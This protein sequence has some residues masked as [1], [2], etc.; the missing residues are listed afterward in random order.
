MS[1]TGDM[2]TDTNQPPLI[3]AII[4][5]LGGVLLRRKDFTRRENLAARLGLTRAELEHLVSASDTGRRAKL[6]KG[7]TKGHWEDVRAALDLAPDDMSA[8]KAAFWG[9][10]RLDTALVDYVRTLRQRYRTALLS[11]AWGGLRYFLV[12]R[13]RIAD[14]F[15]HLIIS[16]EVGLKKPDPRIFR[17]TLARVGVDPQEA[18]FLDDSWKNVQAARRLGMHAIRFR[19]PEQALAELNQLL[20]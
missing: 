16:A 18:V 7:N 8:F 20:E 10:N 2:N 19:D 13:W 3:R 5:D 9:D 12:E 4:W 1:T 11:N 14:A 15:D 17:L 6:G